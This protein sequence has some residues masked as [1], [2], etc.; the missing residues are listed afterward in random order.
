MKIGHLLSLLLIG[1]FACREQ[2][3]KLPNPASKAEIFQTYL[4]ELAQKAQFNGNVLV[5]ENGK[6]VF[7]AATGLNSAKGDS[8]T[9]QSQ[10][11]LA[12]VS[13]QFTCMAIMTLQEKGLLEYDDAVQKHIPE[14][15]YEATIR[16]LMHHTSGTPSYESLFDEKWKP[17]LEADDPA[18]SMNGNEHMVSMMVQHKPDVYFEPG[19][20]YRYSNAAYVL[21]ATIV[22]RVSG[23]PFERYLR[24]NVFLPAGMNDTYVFSP[25]REDPLKNRVY[26]FR[27][28]LDGKN[29][30]DNDYHFLNPVAGDGGIYSTLD[31]LFAWNKALYAEKVATRATIETAFTPAILNNQDTSWY[32]FGWGIRSNEEWGKRV[33]HSGGW[34]GFSTYIE[35][36]L[37]HEHCIIVLTNNSA[38]NVSEVVAGLRSILKDGTYELP[39]ISAAE[40]LTPVLLNEG[41]DAARAKLATLKEDSLHYAIV[42]WQFNY[43]GYQLLEDGKKEE[44]LAIFTI[45]TENFPESA[46][47]WDSQ[48]DAYKALGDTVAASA[49]FKK[50]K[51]LSDQSE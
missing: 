49:S 12:S 42:E 51:E 15:P 11:R 1:V 8:L 45:N 32:G 19:E 18:R 46:N 25:L 7:K 17:E 13:K 44:A 43:K 5:A 48:G 27:T 6:V 39:K 14:W 40:E 41:I 36:M 38:L 28:S 35:R 33:S 24:E 22:A 9:L 47:V 21:L 16:N 37:D 30:L 10:F 31:D 23:Q 2:A 29:R 3:P 34:V 50:A 20:K 26:G 4:D